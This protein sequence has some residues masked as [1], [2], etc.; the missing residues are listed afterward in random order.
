MILILH[1]I[2]LNNLLSLNVIKKIKLPFSPETEVDKVVYTKKNFFILCGKESILIKT[3][4]T[5]K[6]I[7]SIIKGKG[8]EIGKGA[9]LADMVYDNKTKS[10]L[11]SDFIQRRISEFDENGKLINSFYFDVIVGN[12]GIYND[13]ILVRFLG[14]GREIDSINEEISLFG[15]IYRKDGKFL[16]EIANTIINTEIAEFFSTPFSIDSKKRLIYVIVPPN[17]IEVRN[18]S[19]KLIYEIK[20]DKWIFLIDLLLLDKYLVISSFSE[21]KEAH[22]IKDV[23]HIWKGVSLNKMI[24]KEIMK[25]NLFKIRKEPPY[26]YEEISYMIDIFDIEKNKFLLENYLPK[27]KLVGGEE[28]KIFFIKGDTLLI[29]N[30]NL[31]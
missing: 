6:I 29:S 2:I 25:R 26:V 28:N 17:K 13:T 5:G 11:V 27:G 10:I 15:K 21:S 9:F 1:L 8:R 20:K 22:I 12:I 18:L 14:K 16:G 24:K 30:L 7:D 31:K 4:S 23:L 3:D 19:G